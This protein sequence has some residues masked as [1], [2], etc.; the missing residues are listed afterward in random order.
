[1]ISTSSSLVIDRP[2]SEQG[3]QSPSPASRSLASQNTLLTP[4]K[5]SYQPDQQVKFLHLQAEVEVL[6]QELQALKKQR[7]TASQLGLVLRDVQTERT[8]EP[9]SV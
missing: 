1:M 2:S 6:L 8:P 4:M 3:T 7:V 5:S 9:V